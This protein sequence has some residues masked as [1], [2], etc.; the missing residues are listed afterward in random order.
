[1]INYLNEM[2]MNECETN[3]TFKW[4]LTK[5]IQ[6]W[7]MNE[8]I[9]LNQLNHKDHEHMLTHEPNGLG[10]MDESRINAFM[11]HNGSRTNNG[12]KINAHMNQWPK[13]YELES[14]IGLEPMD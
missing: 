14:T 8:S 4:I 1:M 13:T 9:L 2:T 3:L 7:S 11:N 10:Y 5:K 12:P 6:I